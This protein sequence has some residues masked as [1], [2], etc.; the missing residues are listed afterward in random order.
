MC[1]GKERLVIFGFFNDN[2]LEWRWTPVD[3]NRISSLVSF[4]WKHYGQDFRT[5][6]DF[7]EEL[8]HAQGVNVNLNKWSDYFG[9][10]EYSLML[11][12][13]LA[14]TLINTDVFVRVYKM[15]NGKLERDVDIPKERPSCIRLLWWKQQNEQCFDLI[16][17]VP[18][19]V[20]SSPNGRLLNDDL[21]F[22]K[23][24]KNKW[25]CATRGSVGWSTGIHTW[26]MRLDRRACAVSVGISR[27]EINFCDASENDPIRFDVYCKDGVAMSGGLLALMYVWLLFVKDAFEKGD[28]TDLFGKNEFQDGD[29]ICVRLDL[30]KR[31]VTFGRNNQWMPN[32]AFRDIGPGEWYPYFA[33]EDEGAKFTVIQQK[34]ED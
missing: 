2:P 10:Q 28:E 3:V 8:G 23:T 9:M 15:K 16:E 13:W 34:F 29:T 7:S 25:M 20:C 17:R 31:C 32:P 6:D 21:S 26:T 22:E 18:W 33:L 14:L 5:Y 27:K 19:R 1:L 4:L 24:S 30:G 12:T 11:Y